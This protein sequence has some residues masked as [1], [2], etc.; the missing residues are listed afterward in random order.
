MLAGDKVTTSK[1]H[2]FLAFQPKAL[3]EAPVC[4]VPAVLK[5]RQLDVSLSNEVDVPDLFSVHGM[6][7][8]AARPVGLRA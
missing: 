4:A 3:P 6:L 2:P 8:S 7:H 1:E 5:A